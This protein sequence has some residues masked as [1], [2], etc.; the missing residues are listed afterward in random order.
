[1]C[2]FDD[3]WKRVKF[4]SLEYKGLLHL[5]CDYKATNWA[6]VQAIDPRF[7]NNERLCKFSCA[8][9]KSIPRSLCQA[10]GVDWTYVL[11]SLLLWLRLGVVFSSEIANGGVIFNI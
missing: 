7:R 5:P 8:L 6:I 4:G 1:M 9:L 11:I 3:V 10:Y 2:L